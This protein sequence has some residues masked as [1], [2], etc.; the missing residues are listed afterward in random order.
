MLHQVNIPDCKPALDWIVQFQQDLIS[1][2]CR[3][4]VTT[5]N[6]TPEW[7]KTL[8][9]DIPIEW[10]TKICGWSYEKKSLLDY[11][12][13]IAGASQEIK[14]QIVHYSEICLQFENNFQNNQPNCPIQSIDDFV[15]SEIIPALKGLLLSFYS[16][17]L[18]NEIGFPIQ[19]N[20]EIGGRFNYGLYRESFEVSNQH[21]SVCPLCDGG[22]DGGQVDHWLPQKKFPVLS[23]H[24]AN[25]L[26]ICGACNSRTNKGDTTPAAK[27][28]PHP[29]EEWFHPYLRSANGNFSIQI[30]NGLPKLENI[31]ALTQARIDNFD[32]L[33]KLSKRWAKEYRLILKGLLRRSRGKIENQQLQA[34]NNQIL[35]NWLDEWRNDALLEIGLRP[36]KILENEMLSVSMN[37]QSP[38]F[39]EVSVYCNE[40]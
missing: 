3:D 4:E 7:I 28:S 9:D 21:I 2:L 6:V 17:I 23:C 39:Q 20:G 12:R 32:R 16:R 5:D 13:A 14:G 40:I 30:N 36:Y 33:I 22:M 10:L 29:F 37:P 18:Y 8:R 11:M 27:D 15:N 1:A 19:T 26:P 31:D 25:L 34:I 24:P 35:I 38:I